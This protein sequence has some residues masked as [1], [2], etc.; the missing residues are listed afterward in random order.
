M[1]S[2]PS[3]MYAADLSRSEFWLGETDET[4][5]V[6]G[7]TNFILRQPLPRLLTGDNLFYYVQVQDNNGELDVYVA[8]WY[9]ATP[10]DG[11]MRLSICQMIENGTIDP[12]EAANNLLALHRKLKH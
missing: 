8:Q 1:R 3:I 11:S 7:F 12:V 9:I 10:K 5:T 6:T 2:Y 4:G